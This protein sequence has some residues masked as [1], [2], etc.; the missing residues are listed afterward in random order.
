MAQRRAP[1][2]R[3][4]AIVAAARSWI[5]TPYH[6]QASV[7]GVGVDCIGLVRGVWRDLY[8]V[9]PQRLPAYTADWAEADGDEA[10]L[11]AARRHLI[12]IEM[13]VPR[14]GDMVVF[15]LRGDVAAKHAAIMTA[16][17]VMVHA[18]AGAAVAEVHLAPWW[19][20]RIAGTFAFP[21]VEDAA[22][23]APT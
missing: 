4:A 8:G 19:R 13:A 18:A 1:S 9:E 15:R 14:P 2:V 21:G 12:E 6:H 20:R 22:P 11:R 10:L 16:P 23:D 3:R 17:A 5:G 7:R